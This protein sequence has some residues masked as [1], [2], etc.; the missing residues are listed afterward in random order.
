MK[1]N[2]EILKKIILEEMQNLQENPNI[3][4][5]VGALGGTAKATV[6]NQQVQKFVQQVGSA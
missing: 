3:S 1:I 5:A 2:K 4:Q 6:K